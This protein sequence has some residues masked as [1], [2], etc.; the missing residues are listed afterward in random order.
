MTPDQVFVANLVAV[1]LV[2]VLLG[3]AVRQ[4]ALLCWSFVAYL[5]MAVVTNRLI[6]WWPERFYTL[7]FWVV[8]ESLYAA[9][10]ALIAFELAWVALEAFPRARRLSL[11]AVAVVAGVTLVVASAAR[12]GDQAARVGEFMAAAQTGAVWT[13]VVLLAV[14]SWYRLPLH[15]WHRSIALGF[16]LY[17]GVYG[18]LLA[19]VG[20]FGWSA[21]RYVAPLEPAAYAAT[22]GLWVL[23]AWRAED[24]SVLVPETRR[25]LQPWVRT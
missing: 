5:V 17:G 14:A 3:L 16:A 9:L 19:T 8:K 15:A 24:R 18:A 2:A 1:L 11:L 20:H 22:I 7:R 4:R 12:S 25:R 6:V 21:H 23:A 10:M 13:F